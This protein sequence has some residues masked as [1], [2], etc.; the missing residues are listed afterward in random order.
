MSEVIFYVL[1]LV[2][3]QGLF[4]L[5]YWLVFRSSTMHTLNRVYLLGALALSFAIPLIKMP[6]FHAPV[7]NEVE[8]HPLVFWMNG[9]VPDNEWNL[10]PI[11][12][13]SMISWGTSLP[14]VY[15]FIT[16]FLLLRS[17]SYIIGL[18]RLKRKSTP[19]KK[20]WF[21][22]FKT[23][24]THPFSFLT[25]VFIPEALF[26]S[27]TFGQI[28]A[29][30]C[31]HVKRYHSID[32][33]VLDFLVSFL[34]FNPFIY[35]YRNALIEIHEYEA[36]EGVLSQHTDRILY[37][38]VL[39][40]QL[41]TSSYSKLVSHFNV[42]IIKKRI[43]MM[44]K[45]KKKNG[46]IYLLLA[47]ITL[48]LIFAFS[49]KEAMTPLNDVG[50][51]IN[52]FIGPVADMKSKM[53]DLFV[54]ESA[55]SILP[56][57]DATNIRVT[58]TWGKRMHP[59]EKVLKMHKGIDFAC[60]VGTEIIATADGKV[61]EIQNSSGEGYGKM[62]V[63]DHGG[64]LVSRYAQLS[65]F[66]A[67]QGDEVT[68]GQVIALSGN[69]GAST[70]PH[71]HYEVHKNGSP[72]DPAFY[73]KNYKI[74]LKKLP[75]KKENGIG[76]VRLEQELIKKEQELAR[77]EAE[78]A[79]R[80]QE[81]QLAKQQIVQ[82]EL[83]RIHEELEGR[84]II[85]QKNRLKKVEELHATQ[86]KEI[87]KKNKE[88]TK[89]KAKNKVKKQSYK[90]LIDPGHGGHDNGASVSEIKEKELV[91]SFADLIAAHFQGNEKI[92]ILFTREDDQN[93]DLKSRAGLASD[94][95]LLISL[96]TN[97]DSE[98]SKKFTGIYLN[99]SSAFYDETREL[100]NIFESEIGTLNREVKTGVS[101]IYL[102]REANCPAIHVS[103]GFLSNTSDLE[104]LTSDE[105]KRA[106]SFKI[107]E[108]IK[109]S[110]S[111]I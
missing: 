14:I 28:L 22:L 111:F 59:I 25:S 9:S 40:D 81:L 38:E 27:Q 44:N 21:T 50:D 72:V 104:F 15:G 78:L 70:A 92:E 8:V 91:M 82:E 87:D 77:R 26:G 107:A 3:I 102:L 73:I 17:V 108:S 45:Q 84:R 42:Q 34:W 52:A 97:L 100:A 79:L 85:E 48:V 2:C 99:S 86:E 58:S 61:V 4:Y 103:L 39:F 93:R 16:L 32:R 75:T 18:H 94:A 62:I 57:K 55:P 69:S 46:R 98:K 12:S 68:Q 54:Q 80:E 31:E 110:V 1:K 30:E 13:D 105:G 89:E 7:F 96:H 64:G 90:I 6:T 10:V 51:E 88:K 95:D 106:M 35:L 47:P 101:D 5:L 37:Q 20:H 23:S 71:L 56:F 53:R 33:L 76:A 83:Y 41:Q 109:R 60:P 19:I 11:Q 66:K 63:V 24:Q 74:E 65:K 36:D 29:H 49:S 43:L 67:K